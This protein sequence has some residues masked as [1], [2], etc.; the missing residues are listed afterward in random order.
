LHTLSSLDTIYHLSPMS[1]YSTYYSHLPPTTPP[2]TIHDAASI[3][4]NSLE[5]VYEDETRSDSCQMFFPP[6]HAAHASSSYAPLPLH[7][8]STPYQ[9]YVAS[10]HSIDLSTPALVDEEEFPSRGKMD[11]GMAQS[12]TE[13]SMA[14]IQTPLAAYAG[15]PLERLPGVIS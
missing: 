3:V 14:G 8:V 6:P 15:G 12:G 11:M 1:T 4:D 5:P 7:Y 10:R 13:P 2:C 9:P